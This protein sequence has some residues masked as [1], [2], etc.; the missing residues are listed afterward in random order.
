[1]RFRTAIIFVVVLVGA[2]FG[3]APV[4]TKIVERS[5]AQHQPLSNLQ[6]SLLMASYICQQ[7]WWLLVPCIVGFFLLIST[8]TA[9]IR[10]YR[11]KAAKET[12]VSTSAQ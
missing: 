11:K 3:F 12:G 10:H 9:V 4:M 1:M 8:L 6:T 7:M 5:M 2:V